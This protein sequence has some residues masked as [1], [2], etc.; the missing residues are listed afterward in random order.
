MKLFSEEIT[1]R[2]NPYVGYLCK[3][4]DK[5]CRDK[6]KC[7]RADGIKL[8]S[9]AITCGAV[10][11]S[12]AVTKSAFERYGYVLD[13]LDDSVSVRMISDG[14]FSKISEEKAP[15]GVIC[16]IK[17]IDKLHKTLSV[18]DE[19]EC[20]PSEIS[21]DE[22]VFVLE[23]VRDPGN[24]GTVVRTAA[25]FGVDLLVISRDCAD[26]Y[27]PRTLRAAM[28]AIFHQRILRVNDVSLTVNSMQHKGRKVYAAALAEDA[29][30]LGR[31][32]LEKNDCIVI[33]NEGH[34]LSEKTVSACTEKLLIP[35]VPGTE[36]LN[37][38]VASS[39]CLW[40]QFGRNI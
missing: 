37:A 2:Q 15:E 38:A 28:G 21:E 19:A 40:E 3:L 32:K 16:V 12:V 33:G 27:N 17:Y 11:D 25:A 13:T 7:F 31:C 18:N 8:L 6:E 20:L 26:I 9:E 36:S 39:I 1:S 10:I 4:A 5:K 24:L 23:S 14:V 29:S 22:T 35:M 34:G 30:L